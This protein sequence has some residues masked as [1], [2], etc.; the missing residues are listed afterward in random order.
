MTIAAILTT[1]LLT[2]LLMLAFR[3]LAQAIGLID[4]P[5]G[6]KRHVGEVPIIG[7][8]AMYLG[9]VVGVA[10]LPDVGSS[11]SLLLGAGG[12]LILI[13]VIDDR[14]GLP[15]TVRLV[16]Q[17]VAVLIMVFGA[18]IV[19]KDI[20]DPLWI[21]RIRLGPFSLF[22]T[23]LI[24][25]SVINAYNMADGLDGLAGSMVMVA[26]L[27]IAIVAGAASPVQGLALVVAGAVAA[28]LVFNLPIEKNRPVHAFMGDAG[29]TFLG[30]CVVWLTVSVCQG[31]DRVIS[32]VNALWFAAV[33]V[34]D[35]FTCFVR[36]IVAGRSPFHSGRDHLHHILRDSGMTVPGVV[37]TLVS[38]QVAYAIFGIAT[39]AMSVTESLVFTI[40]AVLGIGQLTLI[41]AIANLY[42][43]S[44][45]IVC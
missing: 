14:F 16:A 33:P 12:L 39:A 13:G 34:F 44:T 45:K 21:G 37:V 17:L 7:G 41:R 31:P 18:G 15:A 1:T 42:R 4:K 29:S 6:R 23:A 24:F 30:L 9:V 27:A 2:V 40:W 22:V 28:Y 19:M 26:L 38:L 3:P 43:R 5:G 8:V 35:L 11:F 25:A 10:L 36:R 20:G 32:P